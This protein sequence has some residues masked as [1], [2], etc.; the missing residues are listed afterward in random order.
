MMNYPNSYTVE[1]H[2][3]ELLRRGEQEQLAA[4]VPPHMVANF[5][6]TVALLMGWMKSHDARVQK[7][8]KTY[9]P[10]AKPSKLATDSGVHTIRS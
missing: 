6:R 4:E 1:A 3:D 10:I 2:R 7:T 5:R 9:G 8:F